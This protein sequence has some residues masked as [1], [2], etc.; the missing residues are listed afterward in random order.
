MLFSSIPFLY[1]F[2]PS[3]LIAYYLA[4]KPAKNMVLLLA[5]LVFYGWGEPIYVF[6]MVGTITMAYGFGL[7]IEKAANKKWKK[8]WLIASVAI[9]LGI[10]GYFKY[11]DFFITNVNRVTGLSLPLLRVVLPIGIS[12]YTFQLISYLIDVYRGTVAAQKSIVK[13]ATYITMFPQLIA[14][15]I[16]RYADVERQLSD[17]EI[18]FS[19][20]AYGIRRFVLGLGKKILIANVL[21]EFCSQFR[22]TEDKSVLFFWAYAIAVS[23]Q[24]YFDFSGYSDMAIGL[25]SMLGFEFME[26]FNYPFISKSITEF[27]RRWHM[28]L[29][30][31]FR[32]YVY[33]PLG[34][35][36][37]SLKRNMLNI[38]VVWML[39][40]FWHGAEW[41]FIFWGV[42]FG[43]LLM[44]EKVFL[45]KWLDKHKAF[46]HVYV[47]ILV[48]FSFILFDVIELSQFSVYVQAM[49]GMQ[50]LPLLSATTMYY[51]NSYLL[52]F[53]IA[54]IGATPLPKIVIEKCSRN[55]IVRRCFEALEPIFMIV[56][57]LLCT[58]YLVDGSFN[59]FLYFRF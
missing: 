26:N 54:C 55:T 19:K 21:G 52:V 58:G 36:H 16:V 51:L 42:Y 47:L 18:N 33:I 31:W 24:I 15:P 14:G 28:S 30:T 17:R 27:W 59:P 12:F 45:L 48:V 23:L 44:I 29:G 9:S 50:G 22:A 53:V 32:D 41:N 40:G 43:V 38:F 35:S 8:I 3:V 1:Y 10:L 37:C 5:S 49:L 57:I 34:G 25:G 46:G 11:A 2:L 7:W 13:L 4:P 56:L 20:I 6:L 39:T